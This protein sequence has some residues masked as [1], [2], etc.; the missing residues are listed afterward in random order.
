MLKGVVEDQHFAFLPC[1]RLVAN[2][3][4]AALRHDKTQMQAETVVGGPAVGAQVRAGCSI[5]QL[6]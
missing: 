4:R 5:H 2:G 3:Q 6:Q 1:S